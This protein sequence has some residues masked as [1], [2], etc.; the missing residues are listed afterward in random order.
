MKQIVLIHG[1]GST[2]PDF[3]VDWASILG[4]REVDWSIYFLHWEPLADKAVRPKTVF[5]EHLG[6]FAAYLSGASDLRKEVMIL[7]NQVAL[8]MDP[9]LKTA[10]VGHSWGSVVAYD[11]LRSGW[12]GY[13]IDLLITIGSPLWMTDV[14]SLLGLGDL[15]LN[16]ESCK[17]WINVH[18][19][20]DFVG[21]HVIAPRCV[22]LRR[23][24][25]WGRHDA[26]KY[27]G[28]K[29]ICEALDAL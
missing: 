23:L 19:L 26:E 14:V 15:G 5:S 11:L 28:V 24:W 10:V 1:I 20:L 6:D 8:R 17:T 4:L 25:F 2:P 12:P 27:L 18:N 3:A 7:A 13:G 22:N 21:G 9:R 29:A 16:K